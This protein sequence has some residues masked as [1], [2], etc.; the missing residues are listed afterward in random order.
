MTRLETMDDLDAVFSR[1]FGGPFAFSPPQVEAITAPL[2]RPSVIIAGAGSGKTTVMAARVVWLVGH[3]GLEPDR[4]LGLTFTNKAAAE[5]GMRV[6]RALAALLADA[7]EAPADPLTSTYHAFAGTLITEHGLRLGRETDLR[8]LSDA[9]RFQRMARVVEAYD[10]PL[11]HV[12]THVPTLINQTMVLDGQLSDHLVGTDELRRFDTEVIAEVAKADKAYALHKAVVEASQRR[13]ELSRLVDLYRAA[14]MRDGVMD[15]SDQMAWGAELSE[16]EE[17][18]AELRG[19]YDAVLLDEYQD[20]SVAQR[21][22]LQNL[23]AWAPGRDDAPSLTAVGDPAQGIYG[24]RGAA[25]GNLTEFL[26]DF[27]AA[28][29]APGV[30]YALV[31]SR[32]CAVGVIG[33]A[34][35]LAADFYATSEVVQPLA[36][37]ADSPDGHVSVALHETV[38]D[39]IDD[40][41]VQVQKA[42]ANG[43]PRGEIAILVR[44]TRE[45]DAIVR[46]LRTAGV[47][48]EVVGLSGLLSQPE[49]QDLLALLGVLDDVTDNPAMLRLLT[50]PR[51]RIGH[52]DLRLLG[53][54]ALALSGRV[55]G[56]VSDDDLMAQLARAVEGADP[57][58]IVSLA[59]AVE[60]PGDLPYSTE[61][62]VRFSSLSRMVA[63]LRRH[64][65]EP[66]PELAR[67]AMYA[68]DLDVELEAV[69]HPSGLDNLAL[70]HDA[71]A[72]YAEE[73][74]FASLS[75]L[76]AYLAAEE[77]FNDGMEVSTPSTADSVKLLT[78]HKAKGLEWHTVFVP[79]LSAKV[80]PGGK[81]RNRWFSSPSVL[82]V[83][84]RGDAANVPDLE[85]YTAAAEKVFSAAN[86]ADALME[87]RRLGYVAYTRAKHDLHLSG[88]WWGRTQVGARGPSSFLLGT[89]DWVAASGGEVR[90]WEPQPEPDA[91]NPMTELQERMAWP[92]G[93]PRLD[94]R[95][96]LADLVEAHLDGIVPE[97]PQPLPEDH[98]ALR[99]L[100]VI[101]GELE[102]LIA[103]AEQAADPVRSVSLPPTISATAALELESDPAAFARH[104]ARP[105][106][107]RPSSAARFGTRFHAWVEARFGQQSLLDP[108]DLP[109]QADPHIQSDAELRE[110]TELFDEGPYADKPP[111]WAEVPFS[112]LLGGQQ[113]MGRIDAVYETSDGF[114]VVDWKTNRSANADPLQLAI[115]RLAWA[116]LRGVDPSCVT[117]VFYYV[118]LGEVKR[119]TDLPDR[120]ELEQR[121][122]LA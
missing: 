87:E 42:V 99:E 69:G 14:K 97:R 66:L 117:G 13:I 51:W 92:A 48:F 27:R 20:T 65:G 34:N 89:R 116:E 109:G 53:R 95:T 30:P 83:P 90:L 104:L 62:R 73:D 58:E 44:I 81:G 46:A 45:N 101:E 60:D 12:S 23:F 7:D 75:G 8:I 16:I 54:R 29:G 6:R 21:D 120:T 111:Q 35:D 50:G 115:Y 22:L 84:L 15:F 107:R 63:G 82:P 32:R 114:E 49:V 2:D 110:L 106:P 3:H 36:A 93:L 85:D 74:R 76:L 67:R 77:E 72:A 119:F 47:P 18:G 78:V 98:A 39:E 108:T 118:R 103:E 86:K 40:L 55:A 5:L 9:S 80:F 31:E 52:R 17:V 56:H 37:H 10:Q 112:I 105:M 24:W 59:D 96:M 113:V 1:L 41:V 102:L 88:H 71:I 79:F 43:V 64:V 25:S 100:D 28:D 26:T 57:T 70:L 11:R 94:R 38:A 19:R 68:L 122:G 91:V 33:A 61:A 121:L 4:I